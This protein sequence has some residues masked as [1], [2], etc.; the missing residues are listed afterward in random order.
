MYSIIHSCKHRSLSDLIQ[1]VLAKGMDPN[2]DLLYDNEP[3]GDTLID[4]IPF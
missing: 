3:T 4:L 2:T 1:E